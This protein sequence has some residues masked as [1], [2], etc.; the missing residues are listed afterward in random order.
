MV[1][2]LIIRESAITKNTY[3]LRSVWKVPFP[4]GISK[5]FNRMQVHILHVN[6]FTNVVVWY[7]VTSYTKP[8]EGSWKIRVWE[9]T[10][11][12]MS[13]WS[14]FNLDTSTNNGKHILT[15]LIIHTVT[16]KEQICFFVHI[17]WT[18]TKYSL[19]TARKLPFTIS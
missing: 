7:H 11:L 12:F 15:V 2:R 18:I 17:F 8:I 3:F 1:A 14:L 6:T 13:S 9:C 4:Q 16:L 10:K 5:H 19:F